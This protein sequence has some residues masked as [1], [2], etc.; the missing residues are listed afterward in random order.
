MI[1]NLENLIVNLK[2]KN[3][4]L[5]KEIDN[6]AIRAQKE[7]VLL[8]KMDGS[9]PNNTVNWLNMRN[10]C[11]SHHHIRCPDKLLKTGNNEKLVIP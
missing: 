6:F 11:S 9:R 7:L 4:K 3:K 5:E 8:H 10:W 1:T 2:F